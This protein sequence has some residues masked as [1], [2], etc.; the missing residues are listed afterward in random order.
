MKAQLD[1]YSEMRCIWMCLFSI[2]V[3]KHVNNNQEAQMKKYLFMLIAVTVCMTCVGVSYA[4]NVTGPVYGNWTSSGSPYNVIGN[5]NVPTDSTLTIAAGVDVIFQGYFKFMVDS[6]ATL[7]ACGVEGDSVTFTTVLDSGWHSIR[8]SNASPACSLLYCILENGRATAGTGSDLN[9]GAIYCSNTDP[10]ISD[11]SIRFCSASNNGGGIYLSYSDPWI[12]NTTI[13]EAAATNGGGI[14]CTDSYPFI[15]H[16]DI[17]NCL[18]ST[19]VGW[20]GGICCLSNSDATIAETKINDNLAKLG[21]GIFIGDCNTT[22]ADCIINENWAVNSGGGIYCSGYSPFIYGNTI[23]E[24]IAYNL[25][26]GGI[27]CTGFTPWIEANIISQ[28]AAGVDGGGIYCSFADP[29]IDFNEIARNQAG[30]VVA[31]GNGG[32]LYCTGCPITNSLNKNTFFGNL[33]FLGQGGGIYL[34]SSNILVKNSIFWANTDLAGFTQIMIG[35]AST[36]IV[37]FSDLQGGWPGPGNIGL[38]PAFVDTNWNDYRLQWSSP[39]IDSGDPNPIYNDPDVTRADMGCYFFEQFNPVRILLTPH[40]TTYSISIP[41]SGSSFNYTIWATNID[42]VTHLTNIWCDATKPNSVVTPPLLGPVNVN[43]SGGVI[44]SRVRTQNVPPL[45]PVGTY[46]FN[47]YAVVGAN[48]S[49]DQFKFEKTITHHAGDGSAGWT[50]WGE[51]FEAESGSCV[52]Q[53]DISEMCHLNQNYPNPFNPTTV[54]SYKLQD[55]SLVKLSVY[56][57]S[58]RLVT[59]LVNGWR[60]EGVHEVTFDGSGLSSGIYVYRLSAEGLTASGKMVLVK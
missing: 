54:L 3:E 57:I 35:P 48:T 60:D 53:V 36:L 25:N 16:C 8:Y 33:A 28:N 37:T 56:D 59:T 41:A 7:L 32:G 2:K 39:C 30:S 29:I 34:T 51:S 12:I 18:A 26:G 14:Y 40:T 20:G 45:A 21:G 15:S 1:S 44:V 47:A 10:Y 11:C 6:N 31:A 17:N 52:N 46:T 13:Y 50:N 58:G 5:I 19:L 38:Y 49:I 23:I 43:I 55:A 9:G 24:N 27:Y 42:T 4:T 22:V